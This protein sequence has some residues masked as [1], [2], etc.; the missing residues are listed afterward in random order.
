[1]FE[2]ARI[3]FVQL[4]IL[5]VFAIVAAEAVLLGIGD[6]L[7]GAVAPTGQDTLNLTDG[8]WRPDS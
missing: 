5:H 2:I 7:A 8:R 1:V 6:G 3:V 4:I